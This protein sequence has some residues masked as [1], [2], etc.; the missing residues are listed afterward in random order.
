MTNCKVSTEPDISRDHRLVRATLWMDKRQA[1]QNIIK[2][3]KT[4]SY[5]PTTPQTGS[6][7]KALVKKFDASQ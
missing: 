2:K 7:T 5:Q 6:L 1:R 4:F 3:P